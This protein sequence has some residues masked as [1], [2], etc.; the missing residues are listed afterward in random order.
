MVVGV[1]LSTVHVLHDYSKSEYIAVERT[2][3]FV[4]FIDAVTPPACS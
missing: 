2:Y 1:M 4:S 3:K